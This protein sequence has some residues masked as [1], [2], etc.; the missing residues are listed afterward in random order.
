MERL[1]VELIFR[2]KRV[3]KKSNNTKQTYLALKA[4][5]LC[6]LTDLTEV[7]RF[8]SIVSNF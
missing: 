6:K 3:H 8:P 1:L 4:H 5:N 2:I 7:H